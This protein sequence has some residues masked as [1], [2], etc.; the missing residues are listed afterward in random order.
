MSEKLNDLTNKLFNLSPE[1]QIIKT[2]EDEVFIPVS[3]VVLYDK[4]HP[5]CFGTDSEGCSP[6]ECEFKKECLKDW[7][8]NYLE[9]GEELED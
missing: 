1:E 5:I 3:N 9:Y 7:F 4:K 8:Q 2:V 6:E